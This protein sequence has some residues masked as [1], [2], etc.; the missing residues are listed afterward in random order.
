MHNT[1]VP[2][3]GYLSKGCFFFFKDRKELDNTKGR[4][5]WISRYHQRTEVSN[6]LMLF[7]KL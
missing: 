1:R 7:E 2:R 5:Q 3:S 6:S 4:D